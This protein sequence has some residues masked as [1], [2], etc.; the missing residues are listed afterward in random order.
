[1]INYKHLHYFWVVAKQ[2]GIARASERLHLTPQ[3]ISGQINLLEEYLGET[4]FKKV[5]RNLELT[6]TGRLV[7]SYADEIFSLGSELEEALHGLPADRPMVF[8]VGVADVVPKTIAYRLL[9]P[10]LELPDQVRI[11]CKENSL[12]NLL[13]ELALH[14]IDMVVADGPIPPGLNVRGYNHFL[15]ECGVSFLAVPG[16]AKTLR[17]NFPQSLNG[18]PILLPCDINMVQARLLNWLDGLHIHPRIVGEFDDSALMKVFGQAG[19]GVFIAPTAI[20]DEVA[21]QFGVQIIG[22]TEEVR[23]QFYAISVER[24]ISHPA[25]AAITETARAWLM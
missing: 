24:R 11:V 19:K 17:K 23:E 1:M 20:A 10:A 25:V 4:L 2:G 3:T 15:G 6:D 16:L 8:R 14:R 22:K 5:G 7:L 18:S 13:G 21:S 12:D 9:A